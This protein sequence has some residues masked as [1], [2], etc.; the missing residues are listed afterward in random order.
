[1]QGG[2]TEGQNAFVSQD[3]V[4]GRAIAVVWP[5]DRRHRLPIP[6]TFETVP[7]GNRPAPDVAMITAGPEASC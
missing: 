3:L 4:I 2:A 7:S 6:D 1:M 5:F